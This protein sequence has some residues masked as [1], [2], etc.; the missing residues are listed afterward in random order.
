MSGVAR[1]KAELYARGPISC[2][3]DVTE[4]FEQYTGGVYSEKKD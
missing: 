1:M 3:I 4:R 2:G